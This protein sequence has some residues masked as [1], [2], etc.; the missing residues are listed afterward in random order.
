MNSIHKSKF[1]KPFAISKINLWFS[2]GCHELFLLSTWDKLQIQWLKNRCRLK[3]ISL[4]LCC[5]EQLMDSHRHSQE[6]ES[7][8]QNETEAIIFP[9][10]GEKVLRIKLMQ[11]NLFARQDKHLRAFRMHQSLSRHD[12]RSLIHIR[13]IP[14]NSPQAPWGKQQK[15][16]CCWWFKLFSTD[17]VPLL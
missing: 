7:T 5:I 2:G 12:W 1:D 8:I 13:E 10:L 16:Y 4:S 6:R 15:M 3:E 11:L 9:P 17:T 14:I